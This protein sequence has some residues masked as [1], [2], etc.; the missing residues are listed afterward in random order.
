MRATILRALKTALVSLDAVM[1]PYGVSPVRFIRTLRGMRA[2]RRDLD[3]FRKLAGGRAD[4]PISRLVPMLDNRK[5]Q[6]GIVNGHYFHQDLHVA[7][8]IFENN[9]RRH[10]DVGSR[11]DGFVAHV[12]SFREIE[13]FDFLPLS[14]SVSN[15]R[16]T[17]LD[18]MNPLA[19]DMRH[20][21]DSLSCLHALEHFGLGRYGDRIDP[22]GYVNGFTNMVALLEPN[23]TFYF[24]VPVGRQRIEFNAHR[25]FSVDHLTSMFESHDL[26]IRRFSY[27]GD[28]GALYANVDLTPETRIR[29]NNANYACGIF[30]L[31]KRSHAPAP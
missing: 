20:I 21:C 13:I 16:F 23:G 25:V 22:D 3:N 4:W 10:I 28:D 29:V 5:G 15:I 8:R 1:S 14:N 27:V 19:Q 24:S 17:R 9:P 6:A 31:H 18:L 26:D 11:I 12:A 7:R 30:E 2:F